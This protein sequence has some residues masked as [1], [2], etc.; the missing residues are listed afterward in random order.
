M[1]DV[2]APAITD[3][4]FGAWLLKCNPDV[5]DVV[6]FMGDGN[7]LIDDWTVLDN[8]RSARMKAGDPVVFWISGPARGGPLEPGVWGVGYLTGTLEVVAEF[9]EEEDQE[10]TDYWLDL[11]AK[12]RARFF[13]PCAIP[14]FDLP[15]ARTDLKAHR[16]LADVEVIR[17]PEMGNPSW[18]TKGQW[19][20]LQDLLGES[21][22]GP[23]DPDLLT[24]WRNDE[25]VQQPDPLTR[26]LVERVAV[27]HVRQS[28]K[29]E[30]WDVK[31]VQRDNLG[32]D[33]TA[34]RAGR[35]R[36]IEVKG[37]GLKEPIVLVTPNELRAAREEPG[38]ELAVVT[39]ALTKPRL[40]W[41]DAA[42][43]LAV[44]APTIYRADLT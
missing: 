37:R 34:R 41:Y 30:G 40:H 3:E 19:A 1:S 22:L 26:V 36:R 43:V 32:W 33:L 13:V 24:Q 39:G 27:A 42:T 9:D 23:A 17:Q 8:Y 28:L 31:D 4:T 35:T 20:A 44:A 15:I 16:V 2:A 25:G 10:H 38:W 18:L 21:A 7:D 29:G 11:E 5:W 6:G 14:L 12:A